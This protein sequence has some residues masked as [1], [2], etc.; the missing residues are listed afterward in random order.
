MLTDRAP[1]RTVRRNPRMFITSLAAGS[2]R[3]PWSLVP[4]GN[5]VLQASPF[6]RLT[7]SACTPH[8]T[9][10]RPMPVERVD[11]P[12]RQRVKR[13]ALCGVRGTLQAVTINDSKA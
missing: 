5:R 8:R 6:P 4:C 12:S 10:G 2:T 13:N 9:A 1:Q 3:R 11:T 7:P